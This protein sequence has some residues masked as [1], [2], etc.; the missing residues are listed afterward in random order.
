MSKGPQAKYGVDQ[1]FDDREVLGL[2]GADKMAL[3]VRIQS[4]FRGAVARRR[5]R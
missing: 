4:L 1:I 3:V 5:V 2:R